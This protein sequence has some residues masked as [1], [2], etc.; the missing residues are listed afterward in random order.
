VGFLHQKRRATKKQTDR[1]STSGRGLNP[2]SGK[3]ASNKSV[4]RH[5]TKRAPPHYLGL[6]LWSFTDRHIFEFYPQESW[7]SR[8]K[9]SPWE[10]SACKGR[11]FGD[12]LWAALVLSLRGGQR[13][14]CNTEIHTQ[15]DVCW[16]TNGTEQ[17][18]LKSR[19]KAVWRHGRKKST[20]KQSAGLLGRPG[21]ILTHFVL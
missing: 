1:V 21:V 10:V 9:N 8:V 20:N 12:P 2:S 14:E 19:Q 13:N 3:Q 7:V 6:W 4:T 11:G 15:G 16:H 17:R 5:P 18:E